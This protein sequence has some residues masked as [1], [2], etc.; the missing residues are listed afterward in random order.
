MRLFPGEEEIYAGMPGWKL[1]AA[2]G[3]TI[4]VCPGSCERKERPLACRMFPLLPEPAED[5]SVRARTD[6]RARAVCPLSRQ[7]LSG[8]DPAFTEAV[9]RAGEILMSSPGQAEEL[10]HLA[11][12]QRQSRE[13][14][15]RWKGEEH[16]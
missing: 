3:R 5:G 9:R 12:E 15:R 6:L 14:R 16:V 13:I 4:A 10:R 7:G 1:L 2:E 11:E 8:M